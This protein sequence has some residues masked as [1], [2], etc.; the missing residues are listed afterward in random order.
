MPKRPFQ[1]GVQ[2]CF[3]LTILSIFRF[4]TCTI[5]LFTGGRHVAKPERSTG[6]GRPLVAA[7]STDMDSSFSASRKDFCGFVTV[8]Q[9]LLLL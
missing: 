8:Y 2:K 1:N 7:S 5:G 4:R 6:P 9:F 3:A